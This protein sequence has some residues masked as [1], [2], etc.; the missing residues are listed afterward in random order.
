M[1][2]MDHL[3]EA[4]Q[5]AAVINPEVQVAPAV[6]HLLINPNPAES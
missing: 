4:V 3:N 2:V 6:S 1:R 5:G